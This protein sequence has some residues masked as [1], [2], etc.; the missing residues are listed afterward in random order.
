[1]RSGERIEN[2]G[3]DRRFRDLLDVV[4]GGR[5]EGHR[6]GRGRVVSRACDRDREATRRDET[7]R[8]ETGRDEKNGVMRVREWFG[9]ANPGKP[10]QGESSLRKSRRESVSQSGK[11]QP[12]VN[13]G[14]W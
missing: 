14:S 8:D 7:R 3:G 12:V 10:R 2:F 1:M 5:W 6:L 9:C 13:G 11:Q 4:N